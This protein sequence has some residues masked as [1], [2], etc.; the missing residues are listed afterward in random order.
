[1][2]WLEVIL[3]WRPKHSLSPALG[4]GPPTS[5]LPPLPRPLSFVKLKNF[6]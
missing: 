4:L 3:Q 5:L 2:T 6:E 1:M